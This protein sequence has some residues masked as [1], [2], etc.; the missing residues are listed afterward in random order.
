[1]LT[2]QFNT[3]TYFGCICDFFKVIQIKTNFYQSL[4][5]ILL[6]PQNKHHLIR[7][8]KS[9]KGRPAIDLKFGIVRMVVYFLP[10]LVLVTC[11]DA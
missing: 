10:L 11:L 4:F 8:S 3:L 1:M 9:G 2:S 6:H 5:M 7:P